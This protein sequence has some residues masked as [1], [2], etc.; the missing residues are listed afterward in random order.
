[1][2]VGPDD[3]ER[4]V[5]KEEPA[6]LE[7]IGAGKTGALLGTWPDGMKAVVKIACDKLPSG[8]TAQ[9]GIPVNEH[10]KREFAFSKL[11]DMYG[12]GDL[13][14][15]VALFRHQGRLA[16]AQ[17]FITAAQL[18]QF[19]QGGPLSDRANDGWEEAFAAVCSLP[20]KSQWLRLIVLDLV[21]NSRDRHLN[22][23]GLRI[24]F[25]GDKARYQIVAWDNAVSFGKT[26]HFYHQVFHK[27]LYRKKLSLTTVWDKLVATREQDFRSTLGSLLDPEDV[28]HAWRRHC[29]LVEYPHR[30]PWKVLSKGSDSVKDFPSYAEYFSIDP[31]QNPVQEGS[32]EYSGL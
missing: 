3:F 23:V 9:R 18:P 11:A 24:L 14:P 7:P 4:R 29:F 21:A 26:F 6:S 22:N 16:S 12:W 1:M 27:R 15:K 17:A 10:P 13:V 8:K 31:L 25:N 30:L 28:R 32:F 20:S 5:N 2:A 19:A